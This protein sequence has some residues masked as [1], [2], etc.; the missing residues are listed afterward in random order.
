MV[1]KR[2]LR[3]G[4]ALSGGGVRASVFHLGIL[5]CL[6]DNNLL[7]NI[8][9]IS[10]VS[11]G[12][13]LAG[14]I[15][16]LNGGK[17]ISEKEEY[18]RIEEQIKE[19]FTQ[20]DLEKK[21]ISRF[22]RHPSE[23][24]HLSNRANV[25]SHTLTELW[26]IDRDLAEIAETPVWSINGTTIETG[27]RWRFKGERMG[28]YVLGYV[29]DLKLSLAD[30][31]AT[32]ASFPG[33][34]T[35]FRIKTRDYSWYDYDNQ[36]EKRPPFKYIHI[37]DGGIY[38]NLGVEPLYDESTGGFKDN[39][40]NFLIV[41]DAS[42]QLKEE[43]RSKFILKRLLRLIGIFTDQIRLLRVRSVVHFFKREQTG[44]YLKI[45]DDYS[46]IAARAK[47]QGKEVPTETFKPQ[48]RKSAEKA[49]CYPTTLRKLSKKNYEL[50]Y[51]NG[52][53][54]ALANLNSYYSELIA[55]EK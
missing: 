28:D 20:K 10:S 38:D 9:Y 44:I 12:S 26:G 1:A 34:I 18:A 6:A 42:S 40:I 52:Y 14:L 41:S 7:S 2:E 33:G 13:L 53:E 29:N 54:V 50:I 4:L 32:S 45:G 17:F 27:K 22:F 24:K 16:H 43:K 49:A 5:K 35:P 23:L 21:F 11:G 46:S 25:L 55:V 19:L 51:R 3:I 48:S 36:K 30:A 39:N 15:Y 37:A 8:E 31:M 47:E